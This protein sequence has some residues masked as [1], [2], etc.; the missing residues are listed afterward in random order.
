M[1]SDLVGQPILA[2]AGFQPALFTRGA[3]ISSTAAATLLFAF[4]CLPATFN[5]R[6][7]GATGNGA[8]QETAAIVK[9]VEACTHAGGG[10]IY[11]PPGAISPAPSP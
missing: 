6:D 11:V 1:L 3:R 9:T 5:V 2:A 7:Y 8:T 10:T 4:P